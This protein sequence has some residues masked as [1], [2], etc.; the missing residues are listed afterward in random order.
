MLQYAPI[1]KKGDK[2]TVKNYCP[3]CI[4]PFK[5]KYL[6]EGFIM[7]CFQPF[8]KNGV[9]SSKQSDIRPRESC[10]N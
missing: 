7:K 5:T 9:I 2:Q 6:N 3:V 1:H 8:L 10:I 4:L